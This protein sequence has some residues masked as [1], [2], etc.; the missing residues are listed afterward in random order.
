M[1]AALAPAFDAAALL[2]R[3]AVLPRRITADSRQV[4]AGDAFAAFPGQAADG[5]AFIPDAIA[6]GAGSVL[7]EA[8]SF[9]WN[10]AW[11]VSNVAVDGLRAKLGA[12]ADHVYGSPSHSLLVIGVTGTNGKT[13]CTHWI[14][15]CLDAC[16]RKSAIVGTLG[17][18]LVGDLRDAARTTPD[19]AL[20]HETL[21]RLRDAG[22]R[23]VAMEVSSHGLDQGRVNAVEFDVALFTNLTRDHLDYHGSMEAYGAAKAELFAWPTLR[24]CVINADDPFGRALAGAARARG[25]RVL[26]YGLVAADIVATRLSNTEA[27]MALSIATPWGR[28]E[29]ATRLTGAF[30]AS[31]VL[32]V[33]GVLLACGIEFDAALAALSRLTPPPGRMQRLGGGGEPLVVIDYAHSPDALSQVLAALRP[34]VGENG[35]L[36]CV[37]GCGGDRDPGK[38]PEMGR[39]AAEHADRVVVTSDN[40]RGED[41]VAIAAAIVDGIREAG[42]GSHE[43]ELDRAAAIRLAVAGARG[44]DVVLVAGKGHEDYQETNGER[45]PFSDAAV[46]TAALR[47][48]RGA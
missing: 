37:F 17:S 11:R 16:G 24:A 46:A 19:A 5:R 14:A 12:I 9:R 44:G 7:W 41:P 13:S 18:G 33:L 48:R 29:V 40:P 10:A 34:A 43:V 23:T 2:A 20:V 4:R 28:G 27:G 36:V 15:Q 3:L 42:R 8:L 26:T 38:R 22:A 6:R 32:G 30:N 1:P 31:N 45:R 47:S 21:A 25:Q 35:E 39:V